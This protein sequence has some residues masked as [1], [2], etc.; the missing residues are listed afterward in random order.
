LINPLHTLTSLNP[1]NPTQPLYVLS[2]QRSRFPPC[3]SS[4][5]YDIKAHPQ[6]TGLLVYTNG[7]CFTMCQNWAL[8]ETICVKPSLRKQ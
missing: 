2:H 1:Q 4:G 5:L 3:H 8:P 7:F 6:S